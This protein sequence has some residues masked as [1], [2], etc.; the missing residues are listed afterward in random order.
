MGRR[1]RGGARRSRLLLVLVA[2]EAVAA[3]VLALAA[4]GPGASAGAGATGR[5]NRDLVS[6]LGL[7]D[8]ALWPGA[9]Y[10]RHPSQAD[11]FAPFSD[12]P[13]AFEHAPAGSVV[14]VP[15]HA[16]SGGRP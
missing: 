8:L 13:A 3:L 15:R 11:L 16:F 12:H 14:P 1:L 5:S 7:T 4:P 9:S 6:T 10:S 2:A